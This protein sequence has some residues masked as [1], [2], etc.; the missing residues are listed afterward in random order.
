VQAAHQ[1][2]ASHASASH[3]IE[4]R[5]AYQFYIG[6]SDAHEPLGP[7]PVAGQSDN[8]SGVRNRAR[9][10]SNS[11]DDDYQLNIIS[12]P[13]N[14]ADSYQTSAYQPGRSAASSYLYEDL[15][16]PHSA[17]PSIDDPGTEPTTS[18]ES[19]PFYGLDDYEVVDPRMHSQLP[20]SVL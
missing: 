4:E 6:L 16:N 14:Q 19:G 1:F 9:E 7:S 20:N 3:S 17:E 8:A 12:D 5:D 10:P 18:D 15:S 2:Y 13:S 11:D